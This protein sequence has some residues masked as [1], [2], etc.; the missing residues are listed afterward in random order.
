MFKQKSLLVSMVLLFA[1][2][3]IALAAKDQTPKGPEIE[4]AAK[5]VKLSLRNSTTAE[6]DGM[7]VTVTPTDLD[8]IK[9]ADLEKGVVIAVVDAV[10]VPNLRNARYNVF[11]VKA[12]GR[13]RAFLESNGLVTEFKNVQT[14]EMNAGEQTAMSPQVVLAPP[15]WCMSICYGSGKHKICLRSACYQCE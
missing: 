3:G 7:K 14:T 4:R 12:N 1:S 9:T 11:A 10:G 13:W 15:C 5:S 2:C 6:R 8:N